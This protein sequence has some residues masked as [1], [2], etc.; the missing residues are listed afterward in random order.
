MEFTRRYLPMEW[1]E[2]WRREKER[3]KMVIEEGGERVEEENRRLQW[4][5]EYNDSRLGIVKKEQPENDEIFNMGKGNKWSNEQETRRFSRD[6][7]PSEISQAMEE[8]KQCSILTD[9]TLSTNDGQN[10]YAHS[11]VLAAVSSV[12]Q[13]LLYKQDEEKEI[14]IVLHLDPEV[15]DLGISAVLEFAYTGTI[16]ALNRQSLDHIQVAA[17]CL[18]VP[19][20]VELCSKKEE[21]KKHRDG[22]SRI[23]DENQMNVNLQSVKKLWEERVGCDVKLE[24]GQRVFHGK[25]GCYECSIHFE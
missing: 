24:A 10:F 5:K 19:R 2:R 8:M 15:S 18:G 23:P 4:I 6:T 12:I 7:Y 25:W 22:Y 17:Q 13:Q 9:L 21:R 14:K 3:Q 1:E 20:I 11:F 16:A